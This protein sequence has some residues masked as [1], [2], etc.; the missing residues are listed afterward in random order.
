[1]NIIDNDF[2]FEENINAEDVMNK[3]MTALWDIVIAPMEGKLSEEEQG[4]ISMI[5]ITLKLVAEKARLYEELQE[6]DSL[7][8]GLPPYSLN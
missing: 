3:S 4:M 1:M 8:D 7:T 5:G 6:G 2:D